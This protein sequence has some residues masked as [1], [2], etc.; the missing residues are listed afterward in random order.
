M[1]KGTLEEQVKTL[2]KHMGAILVTMRDLKA[3][4]EALD[5][6]T[7]VEE[8]KEI[9]E[10]L[11]AQKV[12]DEV[13]V[14]NSDAIKRIDREMKQIMDKKCDTTNHDSDKDE[15]EPKDKVKKIQRRKCRY[16]DRGFCKYNK[17]CRFSH[18]D[19]ICKDYLKTHKCE[20]K[21]CPERH[22]KSCKWDQE[23]GGCNR[24]QECLYLHANKNLDNN[25][26]N[27]NNFEAEKYECVS[28]RYTWTDRHCVKE[29]TIR[30]T[31]VFFCLNCDD[32][33]K[34]KSAVYDQ[35]W[36]LFDQ[37]GYLRLDI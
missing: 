17:K 26:E 9:K 20:K 23:K 22:P 33:V 30:S 34:E 2:Q 16:F 36:S 29:H 24:G 27:V 10:I 35:G 5:K 14:E 15:E 32:W 37:A 12:I 18:P 25:V 19:V 1:A 7:A 13:I 6:R 31:T 28:C 11:E 3:T 8:N 4:V 21:G